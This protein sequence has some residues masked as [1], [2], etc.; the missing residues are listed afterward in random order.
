MVSATARHETETRWPTYIRCSRER[1][2]HFMGNYTRS[3]PQ[4]SSNSD[5]KF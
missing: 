2:P 1:N 5:Y 3:S 4:N